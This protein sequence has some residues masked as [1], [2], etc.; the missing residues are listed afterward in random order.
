MT[1]K[2]SLGF[3]S[4][5][6][7]DCSCVSPC[8]VLCGVGAQTHRFLHAKGALYHLGYI[9]QPTF[10][11]KFKFSFSAF[12]RPQVPKCYTSFRAVYLDVFRNFVCF[13]S[14]IQKKKGICISNGTKN[15]LFHGKMTTAIALCM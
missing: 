10:L 8:L 13:Q 9:P 4:S 3:F 14:Y 2:S 6:G 12:A 5:E 15:C 1:L 7:L 11:L